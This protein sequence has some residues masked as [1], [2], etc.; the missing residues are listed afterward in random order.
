MFDYLK[1]QKGSGLPEEEVCMRMREV[2]SAVYYMHDL[3]VTHR[4]IKPENIVLSNVQHLFICRA[5]L[6]SVIL[7]GRHL[8]M[9]AD[10]RTA[11]P[12]ITARRMLSQSSASEGAW[13]RGRG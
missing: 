11:A 9:N 6:S 12:S 10:R 13:K 3:Q 7:A 8:L 5:S 4:D 2:C 1:K